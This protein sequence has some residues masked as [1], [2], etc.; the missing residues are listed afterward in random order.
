MQQTTG[1]R[2][3]DVVIEAVSPYLPYL[4][5]VTGA[6]MASVASAH[7][8]LRKRDV[9]A[10]IAWVVIIW[11]APIVGSLAYAVLGVNR[12]NRRALA[13]FG[14]DE[15]A[16]ARPKPS[17]PR[18]S[19]Q[20]LAGM[21]RLVDGL[22]RHK[23]AGGNSVS[24]LNGGDQAYDSML[25]SIARAER[26]VTLCTYIFDH[27]A[28]GR[29]FIEA[30][31][32]AK[33]R[34][35]EVRVLVDGVGGRYSWPIVVK[36]LRRRGVNARQFLPTLLPWRAPYFNLRNHRKI[37]VVDGRVGYTGGM[38]IRHGHRAGDSTEAISDVHFRFL[39][40][41]VAQL[42]SA[43]A[44]DWLFAAREEL[45]GDLWFPELEVAGP[46]R[47]RGISDG[48]DY[49]LHR[50]SWTLQ[51]ALAC[52]QRRVRFAT[53][54][55]LPIAGMARALQ[56]AARRGVTVDILLPERSNL[57][58]VQWASRAMWEQVLEGGCR[59]WLTPPPFDHTKL[60]V[61]DDDWSFIGSSNWDPR[62]LRLNFEFNVEM[63]D[64]EV[65][66][67][68]D[69][70][71]QQKIRKAHRLKQEELDARPFAVKLLDGSARL[72]SPYL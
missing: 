22:A 36:T 46:V 65:N 23:I 37:L 58:L 63:H 43:F 38:N 69:F 7:A 9:R 32:A 10:A 44:E 39:G 25:A 59:I 71:L 5:L 20:G 66:G 26:S 72:L 27:D 14:P 31:V 62:S 47:A 24:A 13:L 12:V 1:A 16:D 53:P 33:D 18:F 48:P 50:I 56:V 11:I 70:I 64:R 41:V 54:Y 15:E 45:S 57:L 61:M 49:D 4:A 17:P 51:G 3:G 30:L 68:L 55:F 28:T 2:A 60:M 8:A 35:V 34:G 29:Q 67:E 6:V 52:A 21:T 19:A 40:P 42:Q